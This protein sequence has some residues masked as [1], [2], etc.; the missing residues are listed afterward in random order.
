MCLLALLYLQRQFVYKRKIA[1]HSHA[2][3]SQ[4]A[5]FNRLVYLQV[6]LY[7]L[8]SMSP[9]SSVAIH[10]SAPVLLSTL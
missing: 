7:T 3:P 6:Q 4:D 1:L 5:A 9:C 2:W 10:H 8:Y